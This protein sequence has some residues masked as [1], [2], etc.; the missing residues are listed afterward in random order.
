[1]KHPLA[2]EVDDYEEYI[3]I[4]PT[5]PTSADDTGARQ[6][7]DVHRV[8]GSPLG[9]S[10]QSA[11][12]LGDSAV[13]RTPSSTSAPASYFSAAEYSCNSLPF[14]VESKPP[15]GA[16]RGSGDVQRVVHDQGPYLTNMHNLDNLFPSSTRFPV[17][18]AAVLKPLGLPKPVSEIA[19]IR[20]RSSVAS[21]T[22]RGS[23][24]RDS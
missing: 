15:G 5:K 12:D 22:T 8:L 14:G 1:M 6:L 19:I 23:A 10:T 16:N 2:E 17:T 18:V 13:S 4:K 11:T 9:S 21:T 3:R 24:V 7:K 20:S